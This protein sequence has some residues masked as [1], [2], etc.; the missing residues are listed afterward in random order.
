MFISNF[1]NLLKLSDTWPCCKIVLQ[2][3]SGSY[4]EKCESRWISYDFFPSSFFWFSLALIRGSK[5]KH[6]LVQ[7][8]SGVSVCTY[9][10]MNWGI[11]EK[12][13]SRMTYSIRNFSTALKNHFM[14]WLIQFCPSFCDLA[15]I[16]FH[17]IW[18]LR[19]RSEHGKMF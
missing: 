8:N 13:L 3:Q 17:R 6:L 11:T 14:S 19:R 12:F 15:S 2:S 5:V 18:R 4:L 1:S 10:G 7:I 9:L 16:S